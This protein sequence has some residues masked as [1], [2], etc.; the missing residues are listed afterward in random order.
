MAVLSSDPKHPASISEPVPLLFVE[1][2]THCFDHFFL[3]VRARAS[4]NETNAPLPSV[5]LLLQTLNARLSRISSVLQWSL[6]NVTVSSCPL[7]LS[8]Q[9]LAPCFSLYKN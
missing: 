9:T 4:K 1:N 3:S 5:L 8:L 6:L 2:F 7:F